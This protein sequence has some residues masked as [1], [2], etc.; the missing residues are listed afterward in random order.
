MMRAR[1][2]AIALLAALLAAAVPASAAGTAPPS[3]GPTASPTILEL[4]RDVRVDRPAE[5]I[6]VVGGDVTLGPSARVSGDVIVLFGDLRLEPGARIEG[7]EY[8]VGRSAIDWIPGP[9]W[10]A[11]LVLLAALLVYRLAV[12]AAVCAI[13]ATLPRTAAYER[14]SPSWERRPAVALAVGLVAVVIALP[15][16]GLLAITGVGLPA[17][18]VGLAALLVACGAGLALFREGPLW[19]RRPRRLAYAA[20]LLLPPALEVGLLITAAGGL[21]AVITTVSGG[22][23]AGGGA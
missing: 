21:G 17:A 1:L 7:S 14:W 6:V 11:G 13:A 12:W 9:G 8:V 15:L 16:L 22:R 4:G 19:P 18:L 20:Y 2:L 23:R 3:A 5:R 10:V